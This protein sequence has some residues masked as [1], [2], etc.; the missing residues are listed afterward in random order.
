MARSAGESPFGIH[1]PCVGYPS[2][3]S[4]TD[5]EDLVTGAP[6]TRV[7]SSRFATVVPPKSM[8]CFCQNS[9]FS[10]P[11]RATPAMQPSGL[12]GVP[13]AL[14]VVLRGT[15][16][17]RRSA[18]RAAMREACPPPGLWYGVDGR[19]PRRRPRGSATRRGSRRRGTRD[20]SAH[21]H[22]LTR[23]RIA[24]GRC[25][26]DRSPGPNGGEG[27][28]SRR[29]ETPAGRPCRGR[30]RSA[31]SRASTRHHRDLPARRTPYRIPST[32]PDTP[33]SPRM[34]PVP[35]QVNSRLGRDQ[36]HPA[37]SRNPP[38]DAEPEPRPRPNANAHHDTGK[39]A[40]RGP[41]TPCSS[42]GF[43]VDHDRA[44]AGL[45]NER[46]RGEA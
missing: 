7:P 30:R 27:R 45:R 20:C 32:R 40:S 11:L 9:G 22:R 35:A 31:T 10:A 16:R 4:V 5:D 33:V 41:A 26:Q 28:G 42:V 3:V 12:S 8:S 2:P 24:T 36:S 25:R 23:G 15:C 43:L 34:M 17:S 39:Q 18:R 44:V 21:R 14:R 1:R 6:V 13:P 29:G 19:A 46:D 38:P 37:P